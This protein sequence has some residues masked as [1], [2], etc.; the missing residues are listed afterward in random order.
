MYFSAEWFSSLNLSD[1]GCYNGFNVAQ[2]FC[3]TDVTIQNDWIAGGN[4]CGIKAATGQDD[5]R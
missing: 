2:K 5:V 4:W 3:D 1:I